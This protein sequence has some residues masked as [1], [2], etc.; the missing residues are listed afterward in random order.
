MRCEREANAKLAFEDGERL[1]GD[2]K[3]EDAK[4][5]YQKI[6]ED[7]E[8]YAD[9]QD[10]IKYI[11]QHLASMWATEAENLYK[12]KKY[13]EAHTLLCEAIKTDPDHSMHYYDRLAEIEEKMRRK[14]ISFQPCPFQKN[15]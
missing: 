4:V 1:W 3:F 8:Y 14:K 11:N 2:R 15:N 9:A 13:R 10:K 6:P 12:K 5:C 7:S